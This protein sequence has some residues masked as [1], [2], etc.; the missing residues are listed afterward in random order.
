MVVLNYPR[1][2][3]K[4]CIRKKTNEVYYYLITVIVIVIVVSVVVVL[5][6]YCVPTNM[7]FS[8]GIHV[9]CVFLL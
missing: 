6:V 2:S 7:L 1:P 3:L 9:H 5:S 4:W 8:P